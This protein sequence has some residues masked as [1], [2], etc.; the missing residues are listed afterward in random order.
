MG[1]LP[2]CHDHRCIS[3]ANRAAAFSTMQNRYCS[4]SDAPKMNHILHVL[5]VVDPMGDSP[6]PRLNE[7]KI[8]HRHKPTASHPFAS[9]AMARVYFRQKTIIYIYMYTH[10][11]FSLLV[12]LK[13]LL[14]LGLA[15][16]MVQRLSQLVIQIYGAQEQ[17]TRERG[18]STDP[19]R[20]TETCRCTCS[21]KSMP[22]YDRQARKGYS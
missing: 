7:Q 19:L 14:D 6:Y 3:A 17:A 18:K 1:T 8:K 12:T 10:I 21:T 16:L 20:S 22:M 11:S 5:R 4:H 13:R 9:T 2:F 15:G